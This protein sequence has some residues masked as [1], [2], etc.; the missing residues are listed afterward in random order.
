[1][2]S[3]TKSMNTDHGRFEIIRQELI[4]SGGLMKLLSV[5]LLLAASSAF[6]TVNGFKLK[7]GV[8]LNGKLVS[9]PQLIVKAGETATFTQQ[10]AGTEENFIEVI[11]TEGKIKNQD[12]IMMK[13]VIGT[14]NKDGT[15]K[16]IA[17]PEVLVKEN[18]PAR[19][20]T[21]QMGSLKDELSLSIT[22]A[23]TSI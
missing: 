23:R 2:R 4:I 9:S 15:R 11:P 12:G 6:G 7:M 5:A 17:T 18:V 1:M 22:A 20:T 3:E 14:I 8:S 16:V 13:F 21:R 10:K 19:L